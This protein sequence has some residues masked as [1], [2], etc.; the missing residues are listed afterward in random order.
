MK[1]GG[2]WGETPYMILKC[3]GC[4]TIH[5]KAQY[6]CILYI[7]SFIKNESYGW[8]LVLKYALASNGMFL[9]HT[10]VPKE[11]WNGLQ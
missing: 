6:K 2:G 9:E 7:H 10:S 8:K 11:E 5:N 4:T 1:I 3:F